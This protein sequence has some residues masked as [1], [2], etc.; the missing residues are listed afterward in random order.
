MFHLRYELPRL[1]LVQSA[2]ERV[3]GTPQIGPPPVDERCDAIGGGKRA[4][5]FA[6]GFEMLPQ[7]DQIVFVAEH[8]AEG[9]KFAGE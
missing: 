2:A 1:R 6:V 4:D 5:A 3:R 7:Q 8:V 9:L